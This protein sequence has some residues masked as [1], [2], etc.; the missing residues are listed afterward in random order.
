MDVRAHEFDITIK[1]NGLIDTNSLELSSRQDLV[2]FLF[3]RFSW[4]RFRRRS[5]SCRSCWRATHAT[6]TSTMWR[7]PARCAM[8]LVFSQWLFVT[9]CCTSTIERFLCRE[10]FMLSLPPHHKIAKVSVLSKRSGSKFGSFSGQW[11]ASSP[12]GFSLWATRFRS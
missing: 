11:H 3:F 12:H 10:C 9:Q 7:T 1:R 8:R 4:Y 6:C 5:T 2:T